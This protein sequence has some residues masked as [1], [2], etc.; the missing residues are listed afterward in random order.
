[1]CARSD[2]GA[3]ADLRKAE[4]A[5][6]RNRRISHKCL[7]LR[8]NFL[9]LLPVHCPLQEGSGRKTELTCVPAGA[10]ATGAASSGAEVPSRRPQL[11]HCPTVL[12]SALAKSLLRAVLLGQLLAQLLAQGGSRHQWSAE[13]AGLA[14]PQG[15][16]QT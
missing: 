8:R 16:E 4:D 15:A 12:Y 11:P 9:T 13:A 14:G 7:L 10:A 6:H 2:P 5:R 1:M 3:Q